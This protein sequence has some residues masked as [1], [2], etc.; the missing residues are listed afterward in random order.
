MSKWRAYYANG[1]RLTSADQS[2]SQIPV[3]GLVGVVVYLEPPYRRIIDGHDW[4]WLGSDGFDAVT[5][6]DEWGQWAPAP[7]G[8]DVRMLK[9]GAGMPDEEWAAVQAEMTAAR[10]AP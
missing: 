4:V 9:Q 2:W 10:E 8:V 1:L 7:D 6:H 3:A 5:T